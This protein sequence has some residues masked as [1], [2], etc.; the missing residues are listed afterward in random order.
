M[1]LYTSVVGA[2]R[3]ATMARTS[4]VGAQLIESDEKIAFHASDSSVRDA[5]MRG[6]EHTCFP[7]GIETIRRRGES[8]LVVMATYFP[9]VDTAMGFAP[10]GSVSARSLIP[11]LGP[12]SHR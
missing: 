1:T 4:R 7:S 3:A 11:P 10:K 8:E 2:S 6:I 5:A 9:E 12:A